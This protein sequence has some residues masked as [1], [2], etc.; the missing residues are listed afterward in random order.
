M[1]EQFYFRIIGLN[2]EP[3]AAAVEAALQAAPDIISYEVDFET[4]MAIIQSKRSAE[5]IKLIIYNA[6]YNAILIPA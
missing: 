2:D 5:D 4:E 6:G 1:S 3:S